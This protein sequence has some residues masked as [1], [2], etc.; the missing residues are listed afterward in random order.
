[1]SGNVWEWCSDW[2]DREYYKNSPQNNPKGS[3]SGTKRVLRGG[4]WNYGADLCRVAVRL[5]FFPNDSSDLFGFR[6]VLVP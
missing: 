1:M 2:Y 3:S 4:S 5:G 6:L